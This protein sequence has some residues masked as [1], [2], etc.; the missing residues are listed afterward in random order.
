MEKGLY[1]M[2]KNRDDD[3]LKIERI[4]NQ[5]RNLIYWTAKKILHDEDLVEDAVQETILKLMR[6]PEKIDESKINE[7]KNY[8][9]RVSKSIGVN[10]YNK[11]KK[12]L[13][14]DRLDDVSEIQ[15]KSKEFDPEDCVI[16]SESVDI[17]VQA[18][19]DM[20]DKYSIPLRYQKFDKYSIEEIADIMGI[21]VRTVFYR[22]N[23]AKEILAEKLRKREDDNR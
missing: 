7:T 22:L 4:Y 17:I 20:D 2:R 23:K 8:I 16:S 6:H 19:R 10:I 9:S 14:T 5:Y 1:S 3:I 11:Q 18:I 15:E 21:S 12:L 13:N